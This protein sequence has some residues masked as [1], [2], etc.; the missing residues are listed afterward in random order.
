[1]CPNK[2]FGEDPGCLLSWGTGC[3]RQ[4][5]IRF[6]NDLFGEAAEPVEQVM[7]AAAEQTSLRVWSP[8]MSP[9]KA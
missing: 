4:L 9:S 2:L 5:H 3:G 8:L 1:M 6:D 7:H